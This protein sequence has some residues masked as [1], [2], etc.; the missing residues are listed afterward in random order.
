MKYK[1]VLFAIMLIQLSVSAAFSETVSETVIETAVKTI[2]KAGQ[3][4]FLPSTRAIAVDSE[5]D[6]VFMGDGEQISILD[7]DLNLITL[8]PVTEYGQISGIFYVQEIHILYMACKNDGLRMLD[9]SNPEMPIIAGSYIYPDNDLIEINGVFVENQIAYLACGVG[10]VL[11]LDVST[12]RNPVLLSAVDLPAF[13]Y[14]YTLDIFV[15]GNYAWVA[16]LISGVYVIDISTPDKP[17]YIGLMDPPLPGVRDLMISG[18]YLYTAQEGS[19]IKIIDISDSQLPTETGSYVHDGGEVAIRTKNNNAYVAY[20]SSGIRVLDITDKTAPI[21]N[22]DWVYS[23]SG[24]TGISFGTDE[25]SLF[26]T[27]EQTGMHKIDITDKTDMHTI[28]FYDTPAD[29]VSID[30]SGNY[31][32][33]VDNQ[34]GNSPEKEG[35]RIYLITTTPEI[36]KLTPFLSFKGFCAT[37]GT[38]NDINVCDNFAYVA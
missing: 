24:A 1:I 25:N 30:V 3:W 22:P 29:A 32:Y 12:T 5:R 20:A 36:G 2:Q 37:P 10:D 21:D 16:D 34:V 18:D 33:A 26:I 27:S 19:G 11:I 7:T 6:L 28:A 13:Y 31:L 23:E 14:N 35:L 4:P 8:F 9:V 38:A 15:S 17:K